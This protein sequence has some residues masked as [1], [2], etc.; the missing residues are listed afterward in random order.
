MANV[1]F[2]LKFRAKTKPKTVI[3]PTNTAHYAYFAD[4][5]VLPYNGAFPQ[6]LTSFD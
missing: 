6:T 4:F 5:T 3:T 1:R 2:L